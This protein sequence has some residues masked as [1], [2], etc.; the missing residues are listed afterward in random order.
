[1]KLNNQ[2][3]KEEQGSSYIGYL[4]TMTLVE[5]IDLE[6]LSEAQAEAIGEAINA[7]YIISQK[8]QDYERFVENKTF[9]P[10]H[11]N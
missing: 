5:S 10:L 3:S 11:F 8:A 6:S 2:P 4:A 7:L 9:D 1:M